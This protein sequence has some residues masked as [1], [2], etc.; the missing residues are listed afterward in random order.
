MGLDKMKNKNWIDGDIFAVK[1]ENYSKE[2]D[3][4]F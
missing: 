2:Y 3:G 1:I 4:R